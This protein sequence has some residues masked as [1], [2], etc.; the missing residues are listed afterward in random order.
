MTGRLLVTGYGGFV[1]GSVVQQARRD[2]QVVAL[3]QFGV[4]NGPTDVVCHVLDLCHAEELRQI[5]EQARPQALIHT[6]AMADID[7]CQSQQ[8]A[9]EAVNVGVTEH[10]AQL[11]RD[12][13]TKM[14]FCSTD[15]VFDGVRGNYAEEDPPGPLNWYA[16]TKVRAER[17][18]QTSADRGVVA[19]LS[20]V[21]GLPILGTGNSFLAKMIG[22][23]NRGQPV[24]FPANEIRTPIDVIT[25]GR[26][27][28]EL[29]GNDL[30]GVI[31]LA[32]NTRLNRYE[33][34]LQLADRLGYRRDLVCATDSNAMAGRAPRPNDASLNNAKARRMLRTP[35]LS[36][37]QGL[38]LV[39]AHQETSTH[40]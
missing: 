27:L 40:G 13:G 10:L 31:H 34:A 3:S 5:F 7:Q 14:V 28:L 11:C 26:A 2:W 23:L 30:T 37:M 33:M 38:D 32:G 25:L 1:A 22:Q 12:T 36:L 20:L 4:P 21:M 19:R 18:V 39:L 35:M 8:A 24:R 29:A 9:A 15:S 17:A 16:T 6:A